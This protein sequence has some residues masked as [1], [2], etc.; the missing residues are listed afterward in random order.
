M[1]ARQGEA[2]EPTAASMLETLAKTNGEPLEVGEI[3]LTPEGEVYP[4]P[5]DEPVCFHFVYDGVRFD[6]ELT[7]DREAPLVL[8]AR[9]GVLPYSAETA[10][11]R[12]A[13]LRMLKHAAPARGRLELERSGHLR[14]TLS[15]VTPRPRTPVA[16]LATLASLLLEARPYLA[17]LRAAGALRSS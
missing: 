14:M 16:V 11:G 1:D 8:T 12:K 6:A 7:G 10:Y 4:R 3:G 13:V 2:A 17:I 5:G 9:P 15:A